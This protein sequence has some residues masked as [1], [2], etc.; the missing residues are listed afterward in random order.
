[1]NLSSM[2]TTLRDQLGETTADFWA[3]SELTTKLNEGL[4]RFSQEE[5]WPWL[6]TAVSNG[7]LSASATSF[8]LPEGVA[9]QRVVNV[10]LTAVGITRSYRPKRVSVSEGY[11]LREAFDGRTSAWPE[12]YYLVSE[13]D[14]NSDGAYIATIRFIP[15]PSRAFTVSYLYYRT[16]AALSA[17]TDRVDCPIEY[18]MAVVHWAA[19]E[20]WLKE[21]NGAAK[22]GE[23]LQLYQKVV[24]SAR[25]QFLGS[26]EDTPLVA[27]GEAPQPWNDSYDLNTYSRLRIPDTLGP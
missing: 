4:R 18:E 14:A 25:D 20:L 6:L 5:T 16:P 27:G 10:L 17:A 21:L 7:S 15:T 22:A 24:Q 9:P 3:D 13:A 1:M 12:Y 11:R 19:S 2:Q 23:Q 8:T 26:E